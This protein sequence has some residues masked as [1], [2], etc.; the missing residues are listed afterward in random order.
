MPN[1]KYGILN[2]PNLQC[3]ISLL[4]CIRSIRRYLSYVPPT[5]VAQCLVLGGSR[6][7]AV[8]Q[9]YSAAPKMLHQHSNK[10]GREPLQGR[11]KPGGPPPKTRGC[12]SWRAWHEC[13]LPG[14]HV[15]R[16]GPTAT[17]TRTQLTRYVYRRT[18]PTRV[19]PSQE[20]SAYALLVSVFVIGPI[21]RPS[22][23]QGFFKRVQA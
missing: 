2:N 9:T 1:T 11:L 6:R 15:R 8:A 20:S 7:R 10:K 22:M 16:S 19:C 14:I 17:G 21:E 12:R 3:Y 13:R 4:F 5:S 23:A 18:Q